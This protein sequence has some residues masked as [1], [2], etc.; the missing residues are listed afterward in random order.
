MTLILSTDSITG[1]AGGALGIN[2]ISTTNDILSD[3]GTVVLGGVGG[4]NN[5]NIK[6]DFETTANEVMLASGT[7]A[8]IL[9]SRLNFDMTFSTYLRINDG[10]FQYFGSAASLD[11]FE[12]A[13]ATTVGNNS[14]Q[15]GVAVGDA[16]QS[17]YYS[18][19]EGA[20][21][22][23]AN[24]SPLATSADP[25][26]RIYS[27]DA[28]SATDYI[29]FF[30]DQANPKIQWGNGS[31]TLD[32][33]AADAVAITTFE[34]TGGNFQIFRGDASPEGVTTGNI[35]DLHPDTVGGELYFKV[36]GSGN[37]GWESIGGTPSFKSYSLSN[38]GTAGTFYIGGDYSFAAAHEV[39]T[40]GG[41]VTRT[42]GTAGQAHGAHA[43]CVASGAG[44]TDLVLTV[45]GVSITEA[46]V[47]NDSDTEIIVADADTASTNDYFET[48][49]KWLGQITYTL[50]GLSGAFTFNYG[51]VKYEDF[52]NRNFIVNKFE[53]TGEARANETGLNIELLHHK[54]TAFVYHASAFIPNQT[55]LISLA[56]D[57]GTN[58]DVASGDAFAYKR[59]NLA[60]TIAGGGSEGLIIRITTVTNNSINDASAHIGVT[61]N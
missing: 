34:N 42:F 41:T 50:T 47:K 2:L 52:G 13:W 8:T 48:T 24:R 6:F 9:E 38:P 10:G 54:S 27:S 29:E 19:M 49:K 46:G 39:L 5:E 17:G 43:F 20:D 31:L 53:M 23:N 32:S 51:F 33:N 58:N 3:T 26:W 28:T 37:T 59:T 1:V 21:I 18:F 45:T 16:S 56:T 12:M 22:N 60:T 7:G 57:Y 14:M 30:H 55:A 4:T 35:G 44:G 11:D 36:S 25:V 61:L 15:I 40:I